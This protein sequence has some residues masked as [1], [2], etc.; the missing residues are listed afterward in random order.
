MKTINIAIVDDE[1]LFR[2]GISFIL[3]R[4]PDIKVIF[5]AGNG[6]ELLE[7][8]RASEDLPDIIMMDL[9]MPELNGVEASK[10]IN[11][12]FADIKIIALTS[13]D[14]KLFVANMINV[15]AAA[16]LVK[17][18]SPDVLLF[19]IREV[20]IKGYYYNDEVL[21]IIKDNLSVLKE[22]KFSFDSEPLTNREREIIRLICLQYSTK[23][24]ADMLFINYRTVEGHRNNL[25]LKTQSKNMAGLVLYSLRKDILSLDDLMA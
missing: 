16:Y 5:E 21:G 10:I 22:S 17:N 25:L 6:N 11:D 13:Y 4:E 8:L 1:L 24:I 2:S 19:T 3:K 14:S 7:Y 12:E 18:T 23:E 9:K 20:A 15:G